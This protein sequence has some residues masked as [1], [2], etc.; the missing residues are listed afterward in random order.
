MVNLGHLGIVVL[1]NDTT[2]KNQFEVELLSNVG[3][4]NNTVALKS[5]GAVADG[6]HVS[7]VIVEST[8]GLLNDKRHFV[9]GN[10]DANSAIVFNSDLTFEEFIDHT[11][12]HGVVER[13]SHFFEFNVE[14]VVDTLEFHSRQG[15]QHLPPLDAMVVT[16]L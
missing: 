1:S 11:T 14:A 4:V 8:I 15:A 5:L 2:G 6:S 9:F 7:C 12:E 13:L 10:E 3:H 16:R